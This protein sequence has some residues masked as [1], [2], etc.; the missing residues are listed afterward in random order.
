MNIEEVRKVISTNDVVIFGKGKKGEPEC[1]D[2]AEVQGIFDELAPEYIMIDILDDK[3]GWDELLSEITDWTSFPQVF[4][5]GEFIG[6]S[7]EVMQLE[8]EGILE[9]KFGMH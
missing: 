5:Q 8:E 3:E 9:E 4:L 1:G 6:G 7:N 2:T